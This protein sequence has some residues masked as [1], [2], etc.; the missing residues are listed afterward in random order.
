MIPRQALK[1]KIDEKFAARCQNLVET[2]QSI[3]YVCTTADIW[4]SKS[5]SFIGTTV[6]WIDPITMKRRHTSLSC[7]PFPYPQTNDKVAEHL[8]SVYAVYGIQDKI[9]AT[10]TDNGSNFVKAFEVPQFH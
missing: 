6:H 3:D 7:Q 10:V 8:D 5:A 1:R 9:V 2:L 4:S